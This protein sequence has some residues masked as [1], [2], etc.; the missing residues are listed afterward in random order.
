MAATSE[1][2]HQIRRAESGMA[3]VALRRR[4]REPGAARRAAAA[5]IPRLAVLALA[6]LLLGAC[7][8]ITRI[9]APPEEV[10]DRLP[11]LGLPNARFWLDRDPEALLREGLL[12]AS[13]QAAETPRGQRGHRPTAHYLAISGGS[14]NGAFGAGLVVG[15][16]ASGQRPEFLV[17]TGI[18]AG[19]LIAPFAFLG[20]D[21]DDQL[22][23][24]F[25]SVA[26]PDILL[27]R[28]IPVALLFG[29]ALAD[30]AP[31]YRLSPAG[32]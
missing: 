11:I 30:T 12:M 17:V 1:P 7:G 20:P 10:T 14:D 2:R 9:S 19:A 8:G 23:E 22:R 26:P 29:E 13:R 3:G 4:G 6:L 15:W 5:D 24:V 31:L 21:Y 16:T 25:T 27:L 32:T 18:S 28:R